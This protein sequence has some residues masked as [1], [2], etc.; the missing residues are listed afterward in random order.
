[1][2]Y[3]LAVIACELSGFEPKVDYSDHRLE[4]LVGLIIDKDFGCHSDHVI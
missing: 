4:N 1:M 3:K 2:L